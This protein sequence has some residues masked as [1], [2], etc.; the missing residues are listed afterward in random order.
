MLMQTLIIAMVNATACLASVV[1]WAGVRH[2]AGAISGK[3]A[4]QIGVQ[5]DNGRIRAGAFASSSVLLVTVIR[6]ARGSQT[7]GLQERRTPMFNWNAYR[8]LRV[9]GLFSWSEEIK[10]IY[11]TLLLA[12]GTFAS[13]AAPAES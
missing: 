13:A 2:N 1:I 7:C 11:I 9:M 4:S 5:L 8:F 6:I 3:F 10:R 12:L